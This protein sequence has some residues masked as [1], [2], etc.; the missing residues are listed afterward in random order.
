VIV[1][2][3][4]MVVVVLSGGSAQSLHVERVIVLLFSMISVVFAVAILAILVA[5]MV[6]R[7]ADLSG[8]QLLASSIA[9][10]ATNAVSFS[11]LYWQIDRDRPEARLHHTGTK[12]DWLFPQEGVPNCMR[13]DWR[14]TFVDY[15]YLGFST[16]TAFSTTDAVPLT[17]RAMMLRM[18]ESSISL[19]TLIVVKARAISILGS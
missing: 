16:A 18:L 8:I 15:F 17:S 5:A 11:L 3:V 19:V 2:L 13:P 10:W 6:R 14:P 9:I 12:P 7:S 1:V 4:P